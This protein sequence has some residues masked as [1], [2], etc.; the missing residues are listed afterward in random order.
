MIQ[1]TIGKTLDLGQ[2]LSS[3]TGVQSIAIFYLANSINL[4]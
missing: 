1:K 2:N 4:I 3:E